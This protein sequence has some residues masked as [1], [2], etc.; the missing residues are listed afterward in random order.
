MWVG[1]LLLQ[2]GQ[3]R[4]Y[5]LR[6]PKENSIVESFF[7]RFKAE[8]QKLLLKQSAFEALDALLAERI[9]TY[10]EHRRIQS[11]GTNRPRNA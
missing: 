6:G 2:E 1:H 9:R 10:H 3:R 4:S 5:S 8:H 11:C 7:T